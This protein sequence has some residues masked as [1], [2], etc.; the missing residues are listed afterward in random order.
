MQRQ[1]FTS[2]CKGWFSPAIAKVIWQLI[3][4]LLFSVF[5]F[6]QGNFRSLIAL[7]CLIAWQCVQAQRQQVVQADADTHRFHQQNSGG[8]AYLCVRNLV[9]SWQQSQVR[10][11][12]LDAVANSTWL[13]LLAF[14]SCRQG[15]QRGFICPVFPA[16]RLSFLAFHQ[17]SVVSV[18]AVL[19][20]VVGDFRFCSNFN[21]A[22][23]FSILLL[24][25]F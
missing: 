2:F 7:N 12:D 22:H 1:I 10:F 18:S 5:M 19:P 4:V 24:F 25:L 13:K 21:L 9:S 23:Q 3:W 16:L 20:F 6:W 8:A 11:R 17:F 14:P 15:K